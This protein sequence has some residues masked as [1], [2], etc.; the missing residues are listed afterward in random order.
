MMK[1]YLLLLGLI[2]TV[3]TI[4]ACT[5]QSISESAAEPGQLSD[6]SAV[7]SSA[8]ANLSTM[9]NEQFSIYGTQTKFS[10]TGSD[11]R[12]GFPPSDD[13]YSYQ[14]ARATPTKVYMTAIANQ[15]NLRSLSAQIFVIPEAGRAQAYSNSPISGS[16][17]VTNSPSQSAPAE[18]ADATVAEPPCPSGSF[19]AG[20]FYPY[21]DLR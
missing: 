21:G 16:I 5:S 12:G 3:V 1:A 2:S 20:V 18:P 8:L 15:S 11:F 14:I 9:I 13:N 7:E 17:C 10:A 6:L 19:S 4:S